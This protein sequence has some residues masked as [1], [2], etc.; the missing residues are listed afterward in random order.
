MLVAHLTDS[1]E[2]QD[3][4]TSIMGSSLKKIAKKIHNLELMMHN[5]PHED[6]EA[7]EKK[8]WNLK[9]SKLLHFGVS[10]RLPTLR[11]I[12]LS[13]TQK[14]KV[15]TKK[16]TPAYKRRPAPVTVTPRSPVKRS[17][18]L[19]ASHVDSSVKAEG[20][21]AAPNCDGKE[22][23]AVIKNYSGLNT[24]CGDERVL[25]RKDG[26]YGKFVPPTSSLPD[27]FGPGYYADALSR[28]DSSDRP[29]SSF[30]VSFKNTG[31]VSK[32]SEHHKAA[33][34][35]QLS[36][37]SSSHTAATECPPRYA[38]PSA[39]HR[40]HGVML[41]SDQVSDVNP[42][43]MCSSQSTI[44]KTATQSGRSSPKNVIFHRPNNITLH[45]EKILSDFIDL[46]SQDSGSISF[47]ES[48]NKETLDPIILKA[49][50]FEK[51]KY[52]NSDFSMGALESQRAMP[53]L[54]LGVEG[55][56]K[57]TEIKKTKKKHNSNL[58]HDDVVHDEV[59][60]R[61]QKMLHRVKHDLSHVKTSQ[62]RGK[63][64]SFT[65]NV[66]AVIDDWQSNVVVQSPVRRPRTHPSLYASKA[67]SQS[68]QNV[69]N[70]DQLLMDDTGV[71]FEQAKSLVEEYSEYIKI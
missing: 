60:S 32:N 45:S 10:K 5:E 53:V 39:C 47:E 34:L 19:A 41:P 38:S 17:L 42:W 21:F 35:E 63:E 52:I 71:S 37:S 48:V 1:I 31:R 7:H 13:N 64:V 65:E 36:L 29:G 2:R 50:K 68:T 9:M 28:D 16:K 14:E 43:S 61:A 8:N 49:V 51:R 6:A 58:H 15:L 66:S 11:E 12:Q 24:S 25:H 18:S 55:A 69:V 44:G 22:V 67:K 70:L 20:V 27:W 4:M 57:L 30:Q 23:I 26:R 46:T 33:R 3:E 54:T 40:E 56:F 62:I 59:K